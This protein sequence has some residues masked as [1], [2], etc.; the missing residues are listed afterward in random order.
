MFEPNVVAEE[1]METEKIISYLRNN[2]DIF[3]SIIFAQ[4]YVPTVN[5][6]ANL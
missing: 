4:V 3:L 5:W 6:T 2:E 1:T